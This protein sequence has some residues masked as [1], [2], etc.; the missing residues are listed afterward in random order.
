MSPQLA[1]DL[2]W[3]LWGVSWWAAAWWSRRT[4]KRAPWRENLAHRIIVLL[5]L[6]LLFGLYSPR[7]LALH[8]LW[9]LPVSWGWVSVWVALAGFVFTWWARLHLGAL[10][11]SDVGRKN[12][13]H[14]VTSG[15]Y[16]LVRHPIYSGLI[17]AG[18]ATA[19][20]L[21]TATAIAG[22]AIM[23]LGW[24]VK[25]RLEENFL[26]AELG[27]AYDGYG[28]RVPMLVPFLKL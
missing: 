26:R 22:A 24:Y 14:V 6:I 2:L 4:Q 15:P 23:T 21:G 8:R 25:A 28:A 1:I 11:S 16:A 5:G 20:D 17:L 10:W 7:P 18:A 27:S 19:A 12:N 3:L 13:H 9:T